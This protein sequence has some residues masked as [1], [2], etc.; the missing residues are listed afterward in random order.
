LSEKKYFF[1]VCKLLDWHK[2]PSCFQRSSSWAKA[3]NLGN[4]CCSG[5][6]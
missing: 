2:W 3:G 6:N 1:V 5:R 4:W